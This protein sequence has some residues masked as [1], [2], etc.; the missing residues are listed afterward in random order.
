MSQGL[1]ISWQGIV[2]N[3]CLWN[4]ALAA[5]NVAQ[6]AAAG[7]VL[8]PQPGLVGNWPFTDD[9]T[10]DQSGNNNNGT[11]QGGATIGPPPGD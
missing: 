8:A 7:T 3:V 11:L 10:D 9:A 2:W 1:G 5:A 6:H 4:V